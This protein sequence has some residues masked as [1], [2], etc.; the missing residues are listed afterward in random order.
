LKRNLART[1][2]GYAYISLDQPDFVARE[3][4]AFAGTATSQQ[5]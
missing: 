2:S 5:R 4:N 3:I 1:Q